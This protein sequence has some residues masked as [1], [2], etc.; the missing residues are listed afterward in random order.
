MVK[1]GSLG[2]LVF[3]E[4]PLRTQH[5]YQMKLGPW[6]STEFR[7]HNWPQHHLLAICS[8]LGQLA[9][10]TLLMA[11]AL[12]PFVHRHTR[13]MHSKASLICRDNCPLK[14]LLFSVSGLLHS[15][16]HL[17]KLEADLEVIPGEKSAQGKKISDFGA[18]WAQL[19]DCR[20][21]FGCCELQ[22]SNI[23]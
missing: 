4:A 15:N 22:F 17:A 16:R 13:T 18:S 20:Q 2:T 11:E 3:G 21:V 6:E 5:P 10:P 12:L 23:C 8:H 19:C 14:P 9:W 1:L 7:R